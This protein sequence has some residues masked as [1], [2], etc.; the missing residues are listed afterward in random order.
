[1]SVRS[2]RSII[3]NPQGRFLLI[4][5]LFVAFLMNAVKCPGCQKTFDLG[6]SI[7]THQ[8]YCSGLHLVGR[9][10]IK[11]RTDIAQRRHSAKLARI[12]GHTSDDIAEER[13]EL[14]NSLDV[15]IPQ[16]EV[17]LSTVPMHVL[18]THFL[19]LIIENRH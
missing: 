3:K 9:K 12:E 16:Q 11:K 19:S 10:Q 6:L 1:M 17:E 18:E 4:F 14:R 5:I 13:Q 7:K 15:V 2:V 8:R